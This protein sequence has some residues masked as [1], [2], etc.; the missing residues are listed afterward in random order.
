M[1]RHYASEWEQSRRDGV[2]AYLNGS[3]AASTSPASCC[4]PPVDCGCGCGCEP[5][6]PTPPLTPV[7]P[8]GCPN[9]P[10]PCNGCTGPTGPQGYHRIVQNYLRIKCG[11][12]SA[13]M[14]MVLMTPR[15]KSCLPLRSKAWYI[16]LNP[17]SQMERSAEKSGGRSSGSSSWAS[18]AWYFSKSALYCSLVIKSSK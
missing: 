17:L 7:P 13:S 15:Q 11:M 14:L 18:W 8:C 12:L 6:C 4:C 10:M 1:R 3:A 9:P 5:G 16:W 2:V